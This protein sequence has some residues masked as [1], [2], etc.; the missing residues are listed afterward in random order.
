[1][2][3]LYHQACEEISGICPRA[4]RLLEDAEADA[5]AHLDFPAGHRRRIR[6]N[7]VHRAQEA[8]ARGPGLPVETLAHQNAGGRLLG[9]G[10]GLGGEEVVLR[11]VDSPGAGLGR[12]RGALPGIRGHRRGAR[13]AH[14]R[15]R[16]RRQPDRKEGGL[17][18]GLEYGCD[19]RRLHQLSGHYPRNRAVNMLEGH[20]R[21]SLGPIKRDNVAAH[22]GD[23]MRQ[24]RSMPWEIQRGI[25]QKPQADSRIAQQHDGRQ[26]AGQSNALNA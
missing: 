8:L 17:D 6:T 10:R 23:A 24:A 21:D 16:A 14:H 4:S 12:A 13:A 19:S 18:V 11:G 9:D 15:R 20:L 7:N 26:T 3:E 25:Q 2:R 5:L 22:V 1:M